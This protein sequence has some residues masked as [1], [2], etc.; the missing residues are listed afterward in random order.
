[1]KT[2]NHY[3]AKVGALS[4]SRDDA[5]PE[6]VEARRNLKAE[7]LAEHVLRAVNTGPTLTPEQ[8]RRLAGILQAG[9]AA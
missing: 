7:R 6:L 4:R 9:G 1:M 3:K 5:D 8:Y 2:V